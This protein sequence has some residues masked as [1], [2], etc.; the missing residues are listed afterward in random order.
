MPKKAGHNAVKLILATQFVGLLG[1][2]VRI[3]AAAVDCRKNA[4]I[5]WVYAPGAFSREHA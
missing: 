3:A 4:L 5:F 2:L 1:Y